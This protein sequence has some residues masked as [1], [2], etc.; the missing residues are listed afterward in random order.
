MQLIT[1]KNIIK[2]SLTEIFIC[3]CFSYPLRGISYLGYL[4]Q[5]EERIDEK[6]GLASG[7]SVFFFNRYR[8]S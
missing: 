3:I 5:K 8:D 4:L 6:N 2:M 1:V 7:F